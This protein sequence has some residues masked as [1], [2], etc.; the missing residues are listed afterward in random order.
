L[1]ETGFRA[2]AGHL[3][4][5]GRQLNAEAEGALSGSRQSSARAGVDPRP[6]HRFTEAI[7]RGWHAISN[8][9]SFPSSLQESSTPSGFFDTTGRIMKRVQMK[10]PGAVVCGL[11]LAIVLDTIIQITWKLAVSGVPE[12]ASVADTVRATLSSPLFYA[13]MLA[14]GA[15]L[16]NWMRVLA[17]AD[18]SFAQ[19]FTALS[20]I[21]VL[22]ISTRSLH[23]SL[24]TSKMFGV[25]LILL[26]VF[27]ISRTPFRTAGIPG[28]E[29][30]TPDPLRP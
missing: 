13:A 23:E 9:A 2:S 17:R 27:F 6:P 14:F 11:V 10:L 8:P 20:Y 15:Q 29:S 21:T 22:A 19:P 12:N 30:K 25:A 5:P 7:G 4:H 16:F 18:L 28:P 3:D 1:R 26:G 24:S